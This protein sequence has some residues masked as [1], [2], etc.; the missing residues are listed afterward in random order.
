MEAILR[1]ANRACS[2]C[3]LD[4]IGNVN[5]ALKRGRSLR[6]NGVVSTDGNSDSVDVGG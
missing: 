3:R 1:L 6:R 5:S 2:H 4:N